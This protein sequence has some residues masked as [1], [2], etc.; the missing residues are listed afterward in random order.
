LPGSAKFSR[1][2]H[3]LSLES[4]F[5]QKKMKNISSSA[6]AHELTQSHHK[7]KK[8]ASITMFLAITVGTPRTSPR[9]SRGFPV[10]KHFCINLKFFFSVEVN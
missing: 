7:A 8:L 4:Y 1:G 3:A 6:D 10:E 9:P 5:P 2:E